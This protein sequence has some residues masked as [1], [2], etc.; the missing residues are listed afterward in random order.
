M[1][2]KLS[3]VFHEYFIKKMFISVII[4]N[5]SFFCFLS[6]CMT[7]MAHFDKEMLSGHASIVLLR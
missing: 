5:A 6:D 3:Q 2:C 4:Q 7:M 1:V